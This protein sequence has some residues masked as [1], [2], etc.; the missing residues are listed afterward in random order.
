MSDEKV[1]PREELAAELLFAYIERIKA[2]P[3]QTLTRGEVYALAEHLAL[4][5]QVPAALGDEET[6]TVCNLVA[7]RLDWQADTGRRPALLSYLQNRPALR[8][9]PFILALGAVTMAAILS[10]G[11]LA[12]GDRYQASTP[13]AVSSPAGVSGIGEQEA[14]EMIPQYVRGL[15]GREDE[16][17]LMW[18][19][20]RCRGCYEYYRQMRPAGAGSASGGW[21][22]AGR[23]RQSVRRRM[24]SGPRAVSLWTRQTGLRA[25]HGPTTA[26]DSRSES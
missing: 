25:F 16:R 8:R 10:L 15:L 5:S 4:A 7:S 17:N 14:H 3:E 26:E 9:R 19:M 11:L 1:T 21:N 22:R 24:H 2:R 6:E 20:L 23:E 13:A 18:H 12:F